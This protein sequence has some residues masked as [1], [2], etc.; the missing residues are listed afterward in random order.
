LRTGWISSHSGFVSHVD[1]DENP[2]RLTF[3]LAVQVLV[4]AM[5]LALAAGYPPN[6]LFH[7]VRRLAG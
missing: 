7:W 2:S 3:A 4:L 5:P 6:A 1:T